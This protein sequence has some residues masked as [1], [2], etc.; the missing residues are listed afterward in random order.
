VESIEIEASLPKLQKQ[1]RLRAI[2]RLNPLGEANYE[3]L[4]SAGDQTVRREVIARY[5]SAQAAAAELPASTVAMSPA[6]YDFSYKGVGQIGE[7]VAYVFQIRPR[8]KRQGLI[9]GELWLDGET[10]AAIHMSG[11]LVKKPSI[12]VKRVTVSRETLLSEGIAQTQL[13][14]LSVE[15]RLVGLA[16]LTITERP[17]RY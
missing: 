12:F 16:D 10:G 8:K 3:V 9:K 13:T 4:E 11:Y 15:T 6:N 5:L 7:T 14:H 17:W 2:R 1:G